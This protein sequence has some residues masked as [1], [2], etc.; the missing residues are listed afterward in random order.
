MKVYLICPVRNSS[1]EQRMHA[2]KYVAQLEKEGIVVHYPPRDSDQREDGI[3]L[4]VNESNRNAILSSDEIHV[5]WDSTSYGSHFD[6][7]M[8]FMLRTMRDLPI[9]LVTEVQRTEGKSYSNILL[10]L[11]D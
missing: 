1:E 10:E 3:G 2:Q 6:L 11:S 7:G 9:K 5:M 8:V 4:I